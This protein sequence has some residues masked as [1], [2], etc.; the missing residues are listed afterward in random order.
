MYNYCN[1]IGSGPQVCTTGISTGIAYPIGSD[2]PEK[3]NKY[4]FLLAFFGA[5]TILFTTPCF[6]FQKSRPGQARPDNTSWFLVGPKSDHHPLQLFG[7]TD[8]LLFRQIYQA[9][10]GCWD[11]KQIFCTW[12][13]TPSSKMSSARRVRL[14]AF[15]K[16][17]AIHYNTTRL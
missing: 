2:T 7:M 16:I 8:S 3:V 17:K 4:D 11:L 9:A 5:L 15:Y 10:R 6:V 13:S 14:L 1:I 12:W